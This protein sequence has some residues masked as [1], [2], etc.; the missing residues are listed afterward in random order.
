MSRPGIIRRAA[1]F[2]RP[3]G[4]ETL[5]MPDAFRL[6]AANSSGMTGTRDLAISAVV[7]KAFV[8]VDEK[9]TEAAAATA[10]VMSRALVID[11]PTV[12]SCGPSLPLPD[13]GP[14]PRRRPVP[15][16]IRPDSN[17]IHSSPGA[18]MAMRACG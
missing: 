6:G 16:P 1:T 15:R 2:G 4:F 14:T 8:D 17:L 3:S 5:G 13:P 11:P 12:S 10:S 18:R 7:L 9:G